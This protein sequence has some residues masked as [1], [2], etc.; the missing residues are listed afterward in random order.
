[1]HKG[2]VFYKSDLTGSYEKLFDFDCVEK[3]TIE[4]LPDKN[5]QNWV[6]VIYNPTEYV[7]IPEYKFEAKCWCEP[8]CSMLFET[9][10]AKLENIVFCNDSTPSSNHLSEK[11]KIELR[12]D[13]EKP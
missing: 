9:K 4:G 8:C 1:M 5:I 11:V 6:F 2:T 3:I 7:E 10:S 12:V 13:I